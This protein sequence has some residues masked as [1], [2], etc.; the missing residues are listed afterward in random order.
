MQQ[1]LLLMLFARHSCNSRLLAQKLSLATSE[2]LITRKDHVHMV[3]LC[4]I[5]SMHGDT[6]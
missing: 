1:L 4:Y 2:L 5:K 3:Q 6:Q